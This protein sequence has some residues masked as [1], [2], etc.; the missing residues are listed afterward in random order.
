MVEGDRREGQ[1]VCKARRRD[2]GQYLKRRTTFSKEMAARSDECPTGT[3]R[4]VKG[5]PAV[6]KD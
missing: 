5:M 4:E 2:I 6:V 3:T 1:R